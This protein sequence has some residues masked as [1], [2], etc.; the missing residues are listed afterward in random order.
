MIMRSFKLEAMMGLA[1]H[2]F[3]QVGCAA[4]RS[5]M[6]LENADARFVYVMG[7]TDNA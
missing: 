4:G 2:D 5:V 3:L 7:G 6:Q 1:A